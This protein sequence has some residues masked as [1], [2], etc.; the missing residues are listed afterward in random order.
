MLTCARTERQEVL[1]R[2]RLRRPRLRQPP[3][4]TLRMRT[5]WPS[6]RCDGGLVHGT[7]VA[8]EVHARV[9]AEVVGEIQIRIRFSP[10]SS[11]WW[12]MK[13]AEFRLQMQPRRREVDEEAMSLKDSYL[14]LDRLHTPGHPRRPR[15]MASKVQRGGPR[16]V[17]RPLKPSSRH[18][19]GGPE[20]SRGHLTR[21]RP[22]HGPLP[23]R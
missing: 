21:T 17:P 2:V 4:S 19:D 10:S 1:V 16:R 23:Q 14:A 11:R 12:T 20:A 3:S 8:A 15:R 13:L 22:Q 7:T 9:Q 6:I 18:D 5:L